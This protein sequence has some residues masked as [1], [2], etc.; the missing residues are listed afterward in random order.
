MKKIIG[1]IV[2]VK[3]EAVEISFEKET[4]PLHSLLT[5]EKGKYFEVVGKKNENTVLA[6][7][8][9]ELLG[10]KRKEKVFLKE[11][12]IS[13]DLGEKV[14]GRM[15]DFLGRPIDGMDFKKELQIPL[16]RGIPT[17][18]REKLKKTL[19]ETGIKV[20]DFLTPFCEGDKIGLFGG[21]GVGKTVLITE[22]IHNIAFKKSGFSVFAGIGERIREGNELYLKLK[23]LD[24]LK[25]T[26]LYF[27][28]MDKSPAKRARVGLSAALCAG[29]LKEKTQ[30]PVFLFIDN[31]FRYAMAEMEVGAILGNVPSELGYQPTLDKDISLLQEKISA[32]NA[33]SIQAVYVPA[34]DITDPAVVSIFSHLDSFIVLSRKIAEKGIYPAFDSLRS[35]SIN[36]DKEIVG[37]RHY[38][39]AFEVKKIFQKYEELSHI[40]AIL[41]IEELSLRDRKIAKRAERIQRFLTQPFFVA[42]SYSH[43]KG[44]YVSL[45]DTL[46]GIERILNG[47]FDEIDL[48]NLYMIGKIEEAEK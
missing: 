2:R 10:I 36:L 48:E 33:T 41:G 27:G 37:E 5:T 1:E 34:D 14:L 38:N 12:E 29:Y 35:F 15:F 32:H 23:E 25:N 19:V 39:L 8:L 28:E 45:E 17:K 16:F 4:P 26:V 42:E 21:A 3:G 47:D 31:I 46:K 44:V 13:L 22:L 11:K 9:D 40:I 20:I 43:K 7:P 6:L 24:L 30:K 18:K